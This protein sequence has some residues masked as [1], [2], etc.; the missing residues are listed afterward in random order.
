VAI[1]AVLAD[2]Q[3]VVVFI[4]GARVF[5]SGVDFT[6]DRSYGRFEGWMPC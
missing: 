5:S 2:G 3:E 6:L 1:D 4:S